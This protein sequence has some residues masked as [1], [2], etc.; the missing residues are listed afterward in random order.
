MQTH[1]E[2]GEA[3]WFG[4]LAVLMARYVELWRFS[5]MWTLT[6]SWLYHKLAGEIRFYA[7]DVIA[8]MPSPWMTVS[9]GN[10][11]IYAL[12]IHEPVPYTYD[13]IT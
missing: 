5:L 13:T 9:I 12:V 3:F 1:C 7:T 4:Y 6:M 10:L 8:T 11:K 2:V